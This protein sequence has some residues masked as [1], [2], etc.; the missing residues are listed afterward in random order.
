MKDADPSREFAMAELAYLRREHDLHRDLLADVH[1]YRTYMESMFTRIIWAGGALI[2]VAGAVVSF[3]G[4]RSFLQM[5]DSAKAVISKVV[6]DTNEKLTQTQDAINASVV[7]AISSE[8]VVKNAR[9]HARKLD[10]EC[11]L[12]EL[13]LRTS[14]HSTPFIVGEQDA[15]ILS[16]AIESGTDDDRRRALYVLSDLG[17]LGVPRATLW[18]SYG[19]PSV[20][21][22]NV[23]TSVARRM[24]ALA[25]QR[26]TSG[27]AEFLQL[28]DASKTL[29]GRTL[30]E[31]IIQYAANV[32]DNQW[33]ADTVRRAVCDL[34]D[35]NTRDLCKEYLTK[36]WQ[37]VE[38]LGDERRFEML[39]NLAF[40]AAS[41]YAEEVV[42]DL[43]SGTKRS[44]LVWIL[45]ST[46]SPLSQFFERAD[47]GIWTK[48]LKNTA[49]GLSALQDPKSCALHIVD[50]PSN[51]TIAC[52]DDLT[53]IGSLSRACV[54]LAS[55]VGSDDRIRII[56]RYIVPLATYGANSSQSWMGPAPTGGAP[57][58]TVYLSTWT[59]RVDLAP[60]ALADIKGRTEYGT[61]N[62]E[63]DGAYVVD[64]NDNGDVTVAVPKTVDSLR[65]GGITIEYASGGLVVSPHQADPYWWATKFVISGSDIVWPS[66][67]WSPR[68]WYDLR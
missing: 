53:L 42:A 12:V 26:A 29:A 17:R 57:L 67:Y 34:Y 15:A 37:R 44:D 48:L 21:Q 59:L 14:D 5:E 61:L 4:I 51:A 25:L 2:A 24:N 52:L 33:V 27:D 9:D 19:Q 18:R 39:N 62:Y 54:R 1:A 43:L 40:S 16:T 22:A 8:I 58:P 32:N 30:V 3:F 10:T 7:K 68:Y 47:E 56:Q 31:A 20:I 64:L 28:I 49:L 45:G 35:D 46:R 36:E 23:S 41:P 63:R 55:S 50:Y 38:S 65:Q 60:R 11:T 66:G 6:N 13:M